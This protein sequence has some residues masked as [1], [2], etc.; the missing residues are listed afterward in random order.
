M[1]IDDIKT[2][3][4]QYIE[5]IIKAVEHVKE[6]GWGV[7]KGALSK[8]KTEAAVD[9][10]WTWIENLDSKGVID[11]NDP[12]TWKSSNWP[13]H[14]HGIFQNY[15]VGH[16]Q[17]VWDIR[18]EPRIID[19]FEK[20]YNTR[21]LLVS[22]DGFNLSKIEGKT[23]SNPWPHVD[24]GGK[25]SS[26]KCIQGLVN[27]L[28]NGPDDGGLFVYDGS[29]KLHK[30]FFEKHPNRIHPS[31]WVKFSDEEMAH[32]SECKPTKI[33]CDP[34]DFL[35]WDSRTVHYAAPP[36]GESL[37]MAVYVC[38]QPASL[39]NASQIKKKQ[40]AFKDQRTTNHYPAN[41]KL[42]PK[43]PRT[44]G[45]Q[46]IIDRFPVKKVDLKVNDT[47]LK[48]AGMKPYAPFEK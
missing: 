44:Y 37:R 27:L 8:E 32:Y 33:T 9:A 14:K 41:V 3:E 36:R 1:E 15:G 12:D 16:Q 23:H 28:P 7:V 40:E 39:A 42:F 4:A 35:L 20:I 38:M 34:G 2:E 18:T 48:L 10:M 21:K 29:F 25:D 47:L 6:H 31:D 43:E 30:S 26:F 13:S 11:R 24:Q 19:I 46:E 45:N 5:N 17:F 22:F